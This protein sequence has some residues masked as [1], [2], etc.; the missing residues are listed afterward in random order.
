MNSLENKLLSVIGQIRPVDASA[1]EAAK[2]Y[3]DGL[4]KPPGSLGKLEDIAVQIAGITGEIKNKLSSKR[5]I[6]LCSD[7]G[8][9]EEGVSSAPRSVTAEQSVNMTKYATGM[10]TLAKHFGNEMVIVDVGIADDYDCPEILDKKIARGTKN[11]F[12]E[13]A[14]TRGQ[15]ILAIMTGVELAESAKQSGV[16]VI[17]VGEMGIGNTTTSS[18][19]LSVLTGAA[20]QDITGRGA[21]LTEEA[22][23]KKKSIIATAVSKHKPDRNDV[24][25]VLSKVGG[26]DI[27]AM[28]GVFLGAAKCR[29]PVVIDGFISVVAALCAARLS[30]EAAGYMFPSHV[31][32]EKGYMIAAKELKIDPWLDLNMRLGEGSGCPIAFEVMAAACAAANNMATFEDGSIDESYLENIQGEDCFST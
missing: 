25:D 26:F 19:V 23:E 13:P 29:I 15:A 2:S 10:S 18:A 12:I 3:Q 8:V 1:I 11:L 4:I 5:I 9:I 30:P 28:C 16:D 6:V 22:W 21:G 27:A 24:V 31:S 32:Y 7:N 17:G 20:A 14:M